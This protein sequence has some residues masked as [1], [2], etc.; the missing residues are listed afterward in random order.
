MKCLCKVKFFVIW[1][2]KNIYLKQFYSESEKFK[3]AAKH[4][5]TIIHLL[6]QA[7]TDKSF[8]YRTCVKYVLPM[9]LAAPVTTFKITLLFFMYVCTICIRMARHNLKHQY[10]SHYQPSVSFKRIYCNEKSPQNKLFSVLFSIFLHPFSN[11]GASLH[12]LK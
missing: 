1:R 12:L 6:Y 10:S 5:S 4:C 2:G 9:P 3:K 7:R 11:S 8:V